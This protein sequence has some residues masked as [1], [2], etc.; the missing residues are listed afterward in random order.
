MNEI[1]IVFERLGN[2]QPYITPYVHEE[3]AKAHYEGNVAIYSDV[4]KVSADVPFIENPD[5]THFRCGRFECGMYKEEL[6]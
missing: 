5:R 2:D 1:F 3:C 6:I 4:R